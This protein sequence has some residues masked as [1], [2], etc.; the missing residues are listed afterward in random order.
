MQRKEDI[1]R[2]YDKPDPWGY[3][4]H[5][6]D[7]IRKRR[8]LKALEGRTYN[9]A[10]DIG[11]GEGWITKDLPAK[12]IHGLELSEQ[13][14]A[15]MPSPVA[16][17]TEPHGKYDLIVLTGVLY[18]HYDRDTFVQWVRDHRAKRAV[19]LTCHIKAWEVPLPY[20]S[21]YEESFQ[22]RE[23]TQILRRYV[24]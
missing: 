23:Y 3:E 4:T 9:R 7:L 24:W 12:V 15:R 20:E 5:P 18:D 1:E 21:Q 13:A 17:V 2:W 6:D 8:I 14:R 19:V 11:A 22:Y 16:P 10:L